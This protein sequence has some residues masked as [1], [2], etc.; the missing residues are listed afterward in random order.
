LKIMLNA[1]LLS[2][3]SPHKPLPSSRQD[4]YNLEDYFPNPLRY[5]KS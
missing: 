2:V 3:R 5:P 1:F 4:S